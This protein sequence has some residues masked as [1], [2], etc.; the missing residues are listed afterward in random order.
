MISV[1]NIVSLGWISVRS[2]P[3][4]LY[5]N[6]LTYALSDT[7]CSDLIPHFWEDRLLSFKTIDCGYLSQSVRAA[8]DAWHHNIP[9]IVFVETSQDNARVLISANTMDMNTLA[10]AQGVWTPLSTIQTTMHIQLDDTSCWLTD[11]SFCHEVVIQETFVYTVLGTVWGISTVF[12]GVILCLPYNRVDAIFRL[13]A[14][15][16]FFAAPLVLWGAIVPCLQC[17]DF[18]TTVVHEIGHLLGLGHADD[19]F[20]MCGC[21]SAADICNSS[22]L[23]ESPV[24]WSSILKREKACPAQNDVDGIRTLYHGNCNASLWCYDS[25]SY[26]GFARMAVALVYSFTLSWV[27]VCLRT[28]ACRTHKQIKNRRNARAAIE[29]RGV[30]LVHVRRDI[31]SPRGVSSHV[32]L[33]PAR[34]VNVRR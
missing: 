7:F 34:N 15:S 13:V 9:E 31:T 30:Q 6:T 25:T 24:M 33:P 26:A 1:L 11:S 4:G 21:G 17:Y 3:P 2:E 16:N 8:F 10:I 19:A 14:W 32:R 20:Q 29:P 22:L 18:V 5:N 28:F 12:V 23:E 27:M